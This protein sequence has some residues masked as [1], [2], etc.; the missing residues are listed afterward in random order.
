MKFINII[1]SL[2]ILHLFSLKINGCFK[3]FNINKIKIFRLYNVNNDGLDHR[4]DDRNNINE[5]KIKKRFN[6]CR[7]LY[8]YEILKKLE[9]NDIS[10]IEKLYIIEKY[11]EQIKPSKYLTNIINDDYKREWIDDYIREWIGMDL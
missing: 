1:F 5:E 8:Q 4:F 2:F 3:K 11:Y 9:S 6:F 10:N 7:M